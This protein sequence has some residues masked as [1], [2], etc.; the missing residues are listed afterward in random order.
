MSALR[1][2]LGSAVTLSCPPAPQNHEKSQRKTSMQNS[3]GNSE[4]FLSPARVSQGWSRENERGEKGGEFFN[5]AKQYGFKR[6]KAGC[7]ERQGRTWGWRSPPLPKYLFSLS[8]IASSHDPSIFNG[9]RAANAASLLP[10]LLL[11]TVPSRRSME[12]SAPS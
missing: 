11:K 1:G 8:P 9:W 5:K 7:F 3:W 10:V 2:E 6:L 4:E 12:G